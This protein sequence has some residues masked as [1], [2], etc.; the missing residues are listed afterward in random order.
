MSVVRRALVAVLAATA[1]PALAA[2]EA[3]APPAEFSGLYL[4]AFL[5]LVLI[6]ALDRRRRLIARRA[7]P[8]ATPRGPLRVVASQTVGARERV[9]V[10]ELG[11]DWLVVGVAPGQVSALDKQPRRELPAP[12]RPAAFSALFE[13]ARRRAGGER[14]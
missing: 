8:L 13:R 5:A 3:P 14:P 1:L 12:A 2:A 9:V 6:V 7:G 10:L 4:Q 11:D